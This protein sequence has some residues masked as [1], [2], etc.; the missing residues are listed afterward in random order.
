MADKKG[1]KKRAKKL[2]RKA[3][4]LEEEVDALRRA[5]DDAWR[6]ADGDEG[7]DD[8]FYEMFVGSVRAEVAALALL[9][10]ELLETAAANAGCALETAANLVA[11]D[12]VWYLHAATDRADAAGEALDPVRAERLSK[13]LDAASRAVDGD[14]REREA[15]PGPEGRPERERGSERRLRAVDPDDAEEAFAEA[16]SECRQARLED[17]IA[18]SAQAAECATKLALVCDGRPIAD[19]MRSAGADDGDRRLAAVELA[20]ADAWLRAFCGLSL[21]QAR[22][23][24]LHASDPHEPQVKLGSRIGVRQQA[25]REMLEDMWVG[26]VRAPK[27]CAWE[28]AGANDRRLAAACKAAESD[29]GAAEPAVDAG[30]GE[31]REDPE[32]F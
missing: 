26:F 7:S 30:A 15:L 4:A 8:P 29:G 5:L 31:R 24:G 22:L 20:R 25:V 27:D 16:R 21:E 9:D 32:P 17:A 14:R 2:A 23:V 28:R 12:V 3:T 10:G 19:A 13:A 11:G 1:W 6:E 18:A